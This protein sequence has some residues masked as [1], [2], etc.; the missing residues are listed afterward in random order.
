MRHVLGSTNF[1]VG[2]ISLGCVTFGREIDEA[3][4]FRIMDHAVEH[5]IRLFDT[6][7]AYGPVGSS[8]EA[9][10]E[11]HASEC[12]IGR[13]LRTRGCREKIVLQTKLLPP[14]DQSH[15]D[16]AL[17]GSLQR[18]QTNSLDLYLFHNPDPQTPIE[19]SLAA[20]APHVA[21][22]RIRHI[23]CSN[24]SVDQLRAA[25]DAA[26]RHGLPRLEVTQSLYNLAI[27][28]IERDLLPLCRERNVGVQAYSPL[29]AG[30]LT[31]KYTRGMQQFPAGS[32]FDIKPGHARI[33]FGEHQ[34]QI[35]DRLRELSDRSGVPMT[36]LAMAWILRRDDI[37]TVLVGA[38]TI[39]HLDNALQA[40]D[41]DLSAQIE[42]MTSWI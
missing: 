8:H 2:P 25:L 22:G 30:F 9:S 31:G 1:R 32:R 35:V 21:A 20:L 10:R 6:A 11:P 17:R 23:G 3:S 39:D 19:Q 33:Y 16:A 37:D 41:A 7:E 12:V 5:G 14:L 34:F 42:E 4:S 13:W 40:L 38:R 26:D 29:G 28:D 18:L 24:F 27:R 36:R 15:I